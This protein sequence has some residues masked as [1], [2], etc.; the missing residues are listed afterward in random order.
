VRIQSIMMNFLIHAVVQTAAFSSPAIV[1]QPPRGAAVRASEPAML[2]DMAKLRAALPSAILSA[3]LV[4][5]PVSEANAA[6]GGRVGGRAPVSRAAPRRAAPSTTNVY[7][8]PRPVT[9]V[10]MSPGYGGYGGGYGYGGGFGGGISTGTYLGI[11]LVETLIREQQR[12]AYLQQ[13]LRTQQELG[14]DQAMIQQLQMQLNE[15]NSKVDGLKAQ[16][17]SGGGGSA[18]APVPAAAPTDPAAMQMLQQQLL[19]QQKEIAALKASK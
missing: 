6:R 12:Q 1:T 15:Q 7:T 11:S 4:M 2:A 16:Q 9:N 10:Y 17:A 14:R 3:L 19:E 13:Q 8:S 18:P 5:A